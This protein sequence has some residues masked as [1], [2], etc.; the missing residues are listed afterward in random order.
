M[1]PPFQDADY[2]DSFPH[3]QARLHWSLRL[4]HPP[5]HQPRH[6]H[7]YHLAPSPRRY[8]RP[9]THHHRRQ[10]LLHRLDDR[11]QHHPNLQTPDLQKLNGIFRL[12]IFRSLWPES[13][14]SPEV[15]FPRSE[16]SSES[17]STASSFESS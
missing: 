17:T 10:I 12:G 8:R 15:S 13:A 2:L 1:I 14:E 11:S 7:R 9:Q 16:A 5:F 6:G 4:P 3:R